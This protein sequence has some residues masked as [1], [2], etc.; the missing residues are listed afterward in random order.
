MCLL[1]LYVDRT[2]CVDDAL[3]GMQRE[4]CETMGD[5]ERQWETM[6][7]QES[8]ETFKYKKVVANCDKPPTFRAGN[9]VEAESLFSG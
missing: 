2:E 4:T 7:R 8:R 1:E 6:R 9:V 5:N 3:D